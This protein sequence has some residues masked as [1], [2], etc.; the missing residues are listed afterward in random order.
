[1]ANNIIINGTPQVF[2]NVLISVDGDTATEF[3]NYIKSISWSSGTQAENVKTITQTAEP[4]TNNQIVNDPSLN[5]SFAPG[6][7]KNLYAMLNDRGSQFTLQLTSYTTGHLSGPQQNL[8]VSNARLNTIGGG[9]EATSASNPGSVS[10]V[11]TSVKYITG[12]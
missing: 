9:A 7:W 5:I 11:A 10:F 3:N 1:M 6:A 2:N 8:L 12:V 4:I